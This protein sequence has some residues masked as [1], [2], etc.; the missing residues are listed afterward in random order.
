METKAGYKLVAVGG[1]FDAFH[2]GHEAL[3]KKAFEIGES[4]IIGLTSDEMMDKDISPYK[5][6]KKVLEDFLKE[7]SF[8]DRCRIIKLDDPYGPATDD[9]RM[10]AIVVSEE[11]RYMAGKINN[12]REKKGLAPLNVVVIP[13]ILAED[14]IPISSTRVKK[15]K[16]DRNGKLI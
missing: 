1:T 11:T 14:G 2:R 6:R 4:V 8:L 9:E 5:D 7:N 12:I 15:G 16:I 10:D 13:L 3:L